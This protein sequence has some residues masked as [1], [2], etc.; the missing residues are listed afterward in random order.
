MITEEEK[1]IG[2][3]KSHERKFYCSQCTATLSERGTEKLCRWGQY[4][5]YVYFAAANV[6]P[7]D[8]VQKSIIEEE[9]NECINWT[10]VIN[11]NN[12]D[13]ATIASGNL[14]SCNEDS[15]KLPNLPQLLPIKFP[16]R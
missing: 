2:K 5:V 6:F 13:S 16:S 14:Q 3:W 7:S 9:M 1:L 8:F 12:V 10:D 4:S 15:R 11:S